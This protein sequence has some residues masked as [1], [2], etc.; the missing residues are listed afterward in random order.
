MRFRPDNTSGYD[1]ADLR[2][3]NAAW[4]WIAGSS[5]GVDLDPQGIF[6]LDRWA[7]I[8]LT[9]YDDGK[10]GHELVKWFVGHTEGT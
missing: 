2:A 1:A 10:R 6:Q 8:L 3:L 7:E 5:Y 4:D 9:E